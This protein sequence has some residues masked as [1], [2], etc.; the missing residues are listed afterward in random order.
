MKIVNDTAERRV[1]LMEEYN[2][3]FTEEK[4]TIF[5]ADK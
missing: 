4:K 3:K 1:N 5:S 2:N